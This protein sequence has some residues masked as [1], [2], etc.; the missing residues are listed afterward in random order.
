MGW[1][2]SSMKLRIYHAPKNDG[3]G[4]GPLMSLWTNLSD[5][6]YFYEWIVGKESLWFLP[7]I[8]PWQ[9]PSLHKI[10]GSSFTI[11]CF[12]RYYK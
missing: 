5:V 11:W 7:K 2:R 9:A 6:G 4:N 10:G 8:Q 12:K 3:M 1:V